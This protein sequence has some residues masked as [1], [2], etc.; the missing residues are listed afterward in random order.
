MQII[1]FLSKYLYVHCYLL[2]VNEESSDANYKMVAPAFTG[3]HIFV[4]P[5]QIWSTRHYSLIFR[6]VMKYCLALQKVV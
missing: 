5:G 1:V 6:V 2:Q 3:D 4:L